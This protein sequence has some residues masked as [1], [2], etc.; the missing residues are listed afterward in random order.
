MKD[1]SMKDSLIVKEANDYAFD[2]MKHKLPPN[3]V[4]HN[5]NH[6]NQTVDAIIEIGTGCGL[7]DDDLE[8]VCLAGWLH[9][10]GIIEK[11]E[12][13]EEISAQMARDFLAS[14]KYPNTKIEK[15]VGCILATQMPQNP[16]NLLEEVM[17]DADISHLGRKSFWDI[18]NLLRIEREK[19][20]KDVYDDISWMKY[21]IDFLTNHTFHTQ[22]SHLKF[23]N[24]KFKNIAEL[25]ILL[26][27][28]QKKQQEIDEKQAIREE[29]ARA[30]KI[31]A[32]T[33]ERGIET[34]FRV[35]QTNHIRLSAMAD[36]KANIMLSINAI[37]LS[38]V[39]SSIFPT[40]ATNPNIAAPTAILILV[41]ILSIIFA[42]LSTRPKITQGRFTRD[43]ITNKKANLLFFGNFFNVELDDY[44]WGMKQVMKDR[45]YLYSSMIRDFYFLG[46]VLAKKYKYLRICYQVFMFGL[47]L[48]M[49]SYVMAYMA[50]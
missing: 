38:I 22:F 49:I 26:D 6:L 1:E 3:Y 15:V 30:K 16:R 24:Q 31:K 43:D 33:P 27:K 29:T 23:N 11:V 21:Q 7:S 4:Y 20:Y 46:K 9:D 10:L 35:T 37:I 50:N 13:H 5:F 34:M 39:I 19:V 8:I 45:N 28:A 25:T 18:S 47:I 42:T 48:A 14:K 36:N 32:E 17:C 40:L 2:L 12:G 44:E 41:C